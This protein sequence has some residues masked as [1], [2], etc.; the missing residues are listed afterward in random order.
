MVAIGDPDVPGFFAPV[1][2][3]LTDP[4]LMGGGAAVGPRSPTARW[5]RPSRWGS[6]SGFQAR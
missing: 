3:A 2:R 1:H 6:G 5:R 4:I